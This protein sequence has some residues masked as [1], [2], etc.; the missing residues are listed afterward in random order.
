MLSDV[1]ENRNAI[2]HP[3]H[4]CIGK[5]FLRYDFR[6]TDPLQEMDFDDDEKGFYD[7]K[8]KNRYYID[9]SIN[10]VRHSVHPADCLCEY[11]PKEHIYSRRD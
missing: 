2:L 11:D 4:L 8:Y 9:G 10:P 5:R 6:V 3:V 7:P 1:P